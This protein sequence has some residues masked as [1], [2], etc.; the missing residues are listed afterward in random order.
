MSRN[1]PWEKLRPEG[2]DPLWLTAQMELIHISQM[3]NEHLQNLER[4][5]L[6]RGRVDPSFRDRLFEFWYL[7]IRDE[8]DRR[9]L[10]PLHEDHR[11]AIIRQEKKRLTQADIETCIDE[12]GVFG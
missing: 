4:M 1:N 9:G 11:L 12:R 6:G 5:L 2:V 3:D 10:E 7:C 8:M